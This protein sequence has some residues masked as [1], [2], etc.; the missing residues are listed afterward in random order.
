MGRNMNLRFKREDEQFIIELF[1]KFGLMWCYF[2]ITPTYFEII[3]PIDYL[4]FTK[5]HQNIIQQFLNF[6]KDGKKYDMH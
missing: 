2:T 1:Q 6:L 5:Q 3:V 4:D